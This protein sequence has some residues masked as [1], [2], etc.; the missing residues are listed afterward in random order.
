MLKKKSH[1]SHG[2]EGTI[3]KENEIKDISLVA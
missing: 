2:D 1:N 3:Q